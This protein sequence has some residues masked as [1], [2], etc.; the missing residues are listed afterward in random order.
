[1]Q[2]NECRVFFS[3]HILHKN[4]SI[5]NV[6]LVRMIF[7]SPAIIVR[8]KCKNI[9]SSLTIQIEA[10]IWKYKCLLVVVVV[11]VVY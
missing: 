10:D 7:E 11:V 8:L 5:F 6:H 9:V 3:K 2:V 1:M 4:M